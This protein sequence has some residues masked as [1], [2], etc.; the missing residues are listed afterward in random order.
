MFKSPLRYPGGKTRVAQFIVK[1]FPEFDE[2]REPFLGGGS[3]F[4]ETK[5][6]FPDKIFW[7]NDAY[8]ELF[9][10]W[11]QAQ[12]DANTLCEKIWK[13]KNQFADGKELYKYL[14]A[15]DFN[16]LETASAFFIF[17]RITFSGTTL[18][19]GY[20]ESA[21][22]R[23]FTA[24][25]VERIKPLANLLENVEIT[26]LDYENLIKKNGENVFIYLDPPYFSARK[27]LLYGKKGN[28]HKNFDYERFAATMKIC[29]HKWL[30]TLD[31]CEYIRELFSF[32]EISL[33]Q[34][35]YGMRNVNK[36]SSQIGREL[37]IKNY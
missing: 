18:S 23:R 10:F 22:R 6:V 2:Y 33:L 8:F 17:N 37:I 34:F 11:Q 26:N 31:D 28:L 36:N 5:Q 12:F 30:I 16:D 7:I 4:I 21:F 32:A 25:S 19:G 3:V 1:N 35:A 27:S 9:K 20:S 13:L 15:N 14:K 29:K 24:S